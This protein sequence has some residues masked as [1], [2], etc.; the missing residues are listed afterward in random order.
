MGRG[1][2]GLWLHVARERP[3]ALRSKSPGTGMRG[4]RLTGHGLPRPAARRLGALLSGAHGECARSGTVR[5]ALRTAVGGAAHGHV[6][7]RVE[8]VAVFRAAAPPA[9]L[10]R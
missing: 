3:W 1:C 10:A 2:A 9:S 5:D 6:A 7:G 4:G 8:C